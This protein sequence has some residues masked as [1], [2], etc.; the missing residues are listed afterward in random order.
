MILK[1]FTFKGFLLAVGVHDERLAAMRESRLYQKVIKPIRYARKPKS[2][3]PDGP[4]RELE[5]VVIRPVAPPPLELTPTGPP[6]RREVIEK[7]QS[8][9]RWYHSIDLP[10]GVTTPGMY[11]HRR[12]YTCT[13]SQ[14]VW[15][16]SA[17]WTWPRSMGSGPSR[18]RLGVVRYGPS[19]C[20][21]CWTGTY[22]LASSRPTVI[23]SGVARPLGGLPWPAKC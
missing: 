22:R 12:P 1:I 7:V 11:D 8:V 19:M 9:S 13:A 6:E 17:A 4:P 14:T 16:A 15:T 5:P 23:A 2:P 18:W 21:A 20:L 10:H 3:S